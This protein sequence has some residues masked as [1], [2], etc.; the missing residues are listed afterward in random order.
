[1]GH[2]SLR[3]GTNQSQLGAEWN[4]PRRKRKGRMKNGRRMGIICADVEEEEEQE[5]E[6]VHNCLPLPPM[7]E[8]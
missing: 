2:C 8:E 4:H 7:E 1:M 3:R 6:M 5:E